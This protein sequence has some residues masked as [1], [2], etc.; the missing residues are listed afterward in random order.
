VSSQPSSKQPTTESSI[1][2][3]DDA[4]P[5]QP[6]LVLRADE[7]NGRSRSDWRT[8]SGKQPAP[9]KPAA[10]DRRRSRGSTLKM[11]AS[12]LVPFEEDTVEVG[13]RFPNPRGL[14]RRLFGGDEPIHEHR[15]RWIL[16]GGGDTAPF[17]AALTDFLETFGYQFDRIDPAVEGGV[18]C[19]VY[20]GRERN[21]QAACRNAHQALRGA[22]AQTTGRVSISAAQVA[23]EL[24][25][26]PW[27]ITPAPWWS[28][29]A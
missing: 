8:R 26:R 19:G 29:R 11:P 20:H 4:L 12:K 7:S 5:R 17:E 25:A 9:G 13:I 6:D 16:T 18:R 10:D 22:L 14:L 21:R 3:F 28:S 27:P 24:V 2:D 23:G 15:V 1:Q